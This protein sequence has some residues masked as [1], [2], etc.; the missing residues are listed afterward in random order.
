M[1]H[2]IRNA[3]GGEGLNDLLKNFKKYRNLYGFA[4]R[5]GKGGSKIS[6]VRVMIYV[7]D[8]LVITCLP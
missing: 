4:L 1:V 5:R 8:P 3:L 7:D 2:I 6:E